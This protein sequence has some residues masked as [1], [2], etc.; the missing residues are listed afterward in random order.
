MMIQI[1]SIV[2]FAIIM[3]LLLITMLGIERVKSRI[4]RQFFIANHYFSF[5]ILGQ[6]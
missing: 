4:H 6:R 2:I 3:I 1:T 5:F